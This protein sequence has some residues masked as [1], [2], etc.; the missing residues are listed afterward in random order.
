MNFVCL[1]SLDIDPT[2]LDP[3][4]RHSRTLPG[5]GD[6]YQIIS[7]FAYSPKHSGEITFGPFD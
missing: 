7:H 3:L 4:H 6:L 5:E 1:S 2:T